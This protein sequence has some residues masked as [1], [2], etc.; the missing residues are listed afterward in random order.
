MP[1]LIDGHNLI[2]QMHDLSLSDPNDEDKLITRL[3]AL[4]DRTQK[5]MTVVFDPAPY[6]NRPQ[7]GNGQSQHGR[8]T[9][10]FAHPGRKADDVIRHH[11]GEARDKQGLI[12]VTSD[13]AV[14]DFTR[15]CGVRVQSSQDFI[16]WMSAQTAA[17]A[18]TDMKPVGSAK[19][20]VNWS[21]VF[22]EPITPTTP[23]KKP[24]PP[25]EKKGQRRSEQL[26]KQV[27]N[28]R[29]LT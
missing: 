8:L 17:K 23:V 1:L 9:V 28:I 26:K 13:G 18:D 20:V 4:A 3:R 2:G 29:R 11:V 24:A 7:I 21:D 5:Q 16:K 25:P 6:D 27:K 14:A 15:R 10:I 22:K 19:E 12:V